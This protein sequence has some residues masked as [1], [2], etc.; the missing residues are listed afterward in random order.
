MKVS[1]TKY[2]LLAKASMR[3]TCPR[4]ARIR[5]QQFSFSNTTPVADA[6][7]S[8]FDPYPRQIILWSNQ[9]VL[10][11]MR[12]SHP[13]LLLPNLSPTPIVNHDII[14]PPICLLG[15]FRHR[16]RHVRHHLLRR[17]SSGLRP[18]PGRR[19]VFWIRRSLRKGVCLLLCRLPSSAQGHVIFR[20]ARVCLSG[21]RV[22]AGGF[23]EPLFGFAQFGFQQL[24]FGLAG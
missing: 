1:A 11:V 9:S 8:V 3:A 17:L 19:S 12:P 10:L 14:V 4:S 7:N 2:T 6:S 20:G 5:R 23:G 22:V 16:A 18:L 13:P 21:R 24:E 15:L